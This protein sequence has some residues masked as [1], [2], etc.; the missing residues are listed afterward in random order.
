MKNIEFK[1]FNKKLIEEKV[2]KKC[3]QYFKIE[4]TDFGK[5]FNEV[6][7]CDL[8]FKNQ[9]I[10]DVVVSYDYN[11]DYADIKIINNS[12]E[13]LKIVLNNTDVLGYFL[14]KY[15]YIK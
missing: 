2:D 7:N 3:A 4:K 12:K 1:N 9:E 8:F 11:D 14:Y 15:D 10:E 5:L 13:E 6:L